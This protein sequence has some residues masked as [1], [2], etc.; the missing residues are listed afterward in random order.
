MNDFDEF[1]HIIVMDKN[2][3]RDVVAQA[4]TDEDRKKVSLLLG[5][6]P[7]PDPYWDDTQFAPV[8][9]LIEQGCKDFI[10]KHA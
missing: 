6:Q 5:D 4:R 9:K 3:L 2:N 10:K 1:D 7:V 8:F